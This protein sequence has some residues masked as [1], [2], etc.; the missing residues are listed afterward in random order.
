MASALLCCLE[1]Q[2]RLLHLFVFPAA[3]VVF[4]KITGKSKGYG[5]VTF[6]SPDS[7]MK[8]LQEPHKEIDGRITEA[9]NHWTISLHSMN[10]ILIYFSLL[11]LIFSGLSGR[12]RQ[13]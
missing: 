5:F 10:V 11:H 6:V 8:A 1:I 9:R 13:G 3:S 2:S 12:S 7:A 4:D